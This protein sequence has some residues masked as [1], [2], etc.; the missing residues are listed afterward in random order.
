MEK[1]GDDLPTQNLSEE[2]R[3]AELSGLVDIKNGIA[4]VNAL[5]MHYQRLNFILKSLS[6][7]AAREIHVQ[8]V[9]GQRY[10]GTGCQSDVE[11][12]VHGTPGND[13]AAFMDGPTIHV[14]GNAQDGVGNTMNSGKVVVHG[15]SGDIAAYSMRGGKLFIRDDAGYR[16]GIHMKEGNGQKPVLVIGG[17]A[18]DF[19]G[20]Y[21][22]GGILL[23]LGLTLKGG[24]SHR[25][26]FVGTGM[27]GGTIY[28]K[29]KA[30]DVG[31]EVDELELDKGD[32]ALLQPLIEEF[33]DC[34]DLEADTILSEEFRKLVPSS[35][36]PYGMLYT[37]AK[38]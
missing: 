33:C 36:R 34:F 37:Q 8:N 10:I 12:H 25:A 22:A 14:H 35:T 5:N 20:E 23:V 29:G 15:H 21:M 6:C 4:T 19:L 31:K 26:R 28:L 17:T 3:S 9:Y 13:L 7:S 18:Q 27:H 1:L 2:L 32:R 30:A 16:V 24:E 11:L 38:K